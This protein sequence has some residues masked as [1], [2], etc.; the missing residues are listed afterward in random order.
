MRSFDYYTGMVLE[1]YAPGLGLP[2]G[3]GGRYDGVLAEFGAPAAAAGFAIGL[4]RLH[5]ALAEQG[6]M[7]VTRAL[8]CTLGGAPE[9]VF[10]AARTLREA[11]WSVALSG[12]DGPGTV[13][14]AERLGA[15]EALL[16]TGSG[17]AR[18]DGGGAPS[19]PLSE[20]FVRP[21]E[22]TRASREVG[23]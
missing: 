9:D 23:E 14:L 2:I 13:A 16:A 19:L 7:V 21:P 17:I 3:G 4:E 12:S 10:P 20:P 18:L 8:D 15:H 6:C 22:R 5:I 11:G 1:V